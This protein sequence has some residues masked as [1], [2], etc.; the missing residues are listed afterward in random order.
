MAESV[1]S[2]GDAM[3][4]RMSSVPSRIAMEGMVGRKS[5]PTR[6][7][8]MTKSQMAFFAEKVATME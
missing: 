7:E 2:K 4:G 6:K 3:G 8:S 1:H 5:L